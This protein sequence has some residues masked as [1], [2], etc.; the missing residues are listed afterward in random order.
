MVERIC[1][2]G[3]TGSIGSNA[4]DVIRRNSGKYLVSVLTAN[5]NYQKLFEQCLEFKPSLAILASDDAAQRFKC[6]VSNEGLKIK[7]QVGV[8]AINSAANYPGVNIVIAAIV[9]A[10]GLIATLTGVKNGLKN[11]IMFTINRQQSC[12]V[13]I[14]GRHK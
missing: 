5:K 2:L 6:L 7:I 13:F 3:S 9:G 11:G 12:T 8:Q 1:I 4:L 14:H 10:A